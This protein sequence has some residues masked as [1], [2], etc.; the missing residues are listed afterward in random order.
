MGGGTNRLYEQLLV[1]RCQT[2]DELAFVELVQSYS[3]RLRYFLLQLTGGEHGVDDLLQ[4][5]WLDVFRWLPGLNEPA[6]LAAWLYRISRNRVYRDRRRPG[7][8]SQSIDEKFEPPAASNEERF[9]VEDAEQIHAAL[10]KLTAEHREVLV[11]RFL[12][13]MPYEQIAVVVDC[14][15]GTVKSR[16][17]YAKLAMRAILERTAVYE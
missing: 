1:L 10:G 13:E 16:I 8:V 15:V 17:H 12:E 11:L 2:G 3:P 14:E 4:D 6:A 5:V 9:L 7:I